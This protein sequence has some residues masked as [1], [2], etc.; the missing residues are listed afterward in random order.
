[1]KYLDLDYSQKKYLVV[2]YESI[3]EEIELGKTHGQIVRNLIHDGN[4]LKPS[5][6]LYLYIY[7]H[8]QSVKEITTKIRSELFEAKI[9]QIKQN[10][11]LSFSNSNLPDYF[12]QQEMM[13]HL[14]HQAAEKAL[15]IL[16]HFFLH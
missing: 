4:E 8:Q 9:E 11:E 1:M 14:G 12:K 16:L 3:L 10:H 7:N 15:H 5:E 13:K 2:L 6:E